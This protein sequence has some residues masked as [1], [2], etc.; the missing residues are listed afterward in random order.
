MPPVLITPLVAKYKRTAIK[1]IKFL[2]QDL[3][4]NNSKVIH[5]FIHHLSIKIMP[6]F[7][8]QLFNYQLV[9]RV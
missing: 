3:S 6:Y 8:Y 5:Y 9:F 1:K 4:I 7:I 2:L